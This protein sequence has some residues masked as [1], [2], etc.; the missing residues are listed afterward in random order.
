[1]AHMTTSRPGRT[2]D[3]RDAPRAHEPRLPADASSAGPL[4]AV[5]GAP[6]KSASLVLVGGFA[7]IVACLFVF[8]TVAEGIRENEV[9]VLDTLATPFLHG[10][11]SPPLDAV[12]IG[13]T[14]LGSG[15]VLA[16]LVALAATALSARRRL[17]AALFLIVSAG[18]AFLLNGI[19]KPFFHRP[20]PQLPWSHVLPDY[21]FPSGHT[22]DSA[23]CFI[24]IAVIV[25]SIAGRRAGALTLI[26]MTLVTAL[27]GV[28]RI[29]LGFHYFTDVVG[30][31]IAGLAWLLVALAAFRSRRLAPLWEPH[32]V[33]PA[34]RRARTPDIR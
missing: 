5:V 25:W 31:A 2:E 32:P 18:G 16:V 10:L 8:G 11:A 12:M 13:A 23:A 27:I 17:G 6:A 29:Y 24:A 7:T 28:S 14:T 9:F 21:S 22:M 20:R 3:V 33:P 26:A 34:E 19:M 4:P 30:G 1:M 15:F